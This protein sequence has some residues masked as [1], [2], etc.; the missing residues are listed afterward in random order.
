MPEID[1]KESDLAPEA[2]RISFGD[3]VKHADLILAVLA[4][5]Q[6]IDSLAPGASV[7]LATLKARHHSHEIEW[8]MG[9]LKCVK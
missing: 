9:T 1:L 6:S 2:S 4:A 5:W 7:K 3:I 8:D